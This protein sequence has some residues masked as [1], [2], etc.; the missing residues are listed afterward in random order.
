MELREFR[1][2]SLVGCCVHKL[3]PKILF[4]IFILKTVQPSIIGPS[5]GTFV[6]NR[7]IMDGVLIASD[8]VDSRIRSRKSGVI[9]KIDLE[10]PEDH[11]ERSFVVYMIDALWV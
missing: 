7:Q 8:L 10:K 3:L 4:N 2:I 9:F 11:A 5:Q 1:S 6:Q